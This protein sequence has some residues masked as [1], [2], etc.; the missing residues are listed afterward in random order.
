MI[1]WKEKSQKLLLQYHPQRNFES[2]QLK[3]L[4]VTEHSVQVEVGWLDIILRTELIAH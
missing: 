2:S 1:I 3:L 4:L